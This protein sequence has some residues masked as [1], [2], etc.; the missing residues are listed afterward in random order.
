MAHVLP[1]LALAY[2][3]IAEVPLRRDPH[4]LFVSPDDFRRQVE[5][6][7][8]WGYEFVRFG[9]LA[10]RVQLAQGQNCAALTFDDGLV[11]NLET[12]VP[13]LREVGAPAT[14][15]VV[16]GWLGAAYPWATWT[17]ILTADEVRALAGE[18]V[19]IGSHTTR[20]QDLSTL[21]YEESLA[22]LV[23]SK[24]ELEDVA[25]RPVE[26]LAYPFGRAGEAAIAACRTAGYRAA[27]RA[28]GAGSWDTP[29]ELPRQDMDNRCSLLGLRLKRDGR[30]EPLMRFRPARAARR[31][32]RRARSVAG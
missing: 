10:E 8:S 21:G 31:L 16:S 18:G 5:R 9:E 26:T 20:H 24:Q 13:L 29:H 23:Q 12:L 17:R 30:Y 2:H 11:D 14:V 22:D 27:C 28:S 32:A 4:G 25:G 3:G 7:S 1:P 6:L 15:F 19:E